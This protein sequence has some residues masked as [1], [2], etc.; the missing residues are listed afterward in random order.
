MTYYDHEIARVGNIPAALKLQNEQGQTRWMT[1]TPE[2]I[3]Q[4]L[5]I[6][7]KSEDWIMIDFTQAQEKA[8]TIW[9]N[10]K[11]M[12]I[13]EGAPYDGDDWFMVDS[14]IP[15]LEGKVDINIY[16][17]EE[18][19]GTVIIRCV[20]YEIQTRPDGTQVTNCETWFNVF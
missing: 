7:N 10:E 20:A 18:E 1:V 13:L 3:Q 14:A 16:D 9:A 8:L 2:Q 11:L 6:L 19:D 17:H 4:I 5:E 12:D 15:E